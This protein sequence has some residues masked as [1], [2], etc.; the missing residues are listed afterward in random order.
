MAQ[1]NS[2]DPTDLDTLAGGDPEIRA[3]LDFPPVL[4]RTKRHDGWSEQNQ[5]RFIAGLVECGDYERA[6][7]AV[8]RTGSGAYK[9]RRAEGSGPFREAWDKAIE[10]YH[11]RNPNVVPIGRPTRGAIAAA[12]AG[13][14]PEGWVDPSEYY[15]SPKEFADG[16]L[17]KYLLKLHQERAARLAGRIVEADFYVR[18]LTWLE[19][20]IDLGG[21]AIELLEELKRGGTPVGNIVATPMSVLLDSVR[22]AYWAEKNEPDRPPLGDLGHHDGEISTGQP[23]ESQYWPERDGTFQQWQSG[24]SEAQ[25]LA[26]EAQRAWEEKARADAEAWA[27]RVG[28]EG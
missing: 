4:R 3:L 6:A 8:G 21:N 11:R 12:A 9:L 23:S 13:K 25:R 17:K 19:V 7:Q 24:P 5:R 22:R 10:L 15:L 28:G 16:I 18:Q 2:I 26:A 27:K 20:A 1:D 14:P